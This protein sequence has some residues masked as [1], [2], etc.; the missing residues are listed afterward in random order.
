MPPDASRHRSPIR[1]SNFTLSQG[2]ADHFGHVKAGASRPALRA[3]TAL[4]RPNR[5]AQWLPCGRHGVHHRPVRPRPTIRGRR[6]GRRV[7]PNLQRLVRQA[8]RQPP[9]PHS[10]CNV[11]P[12]RRSSR[13]A[14]AHR[15]FYAQVISVQ[16]C[17]AR[18]AVP[19]PLRYSPTFRLTFASPENPRAR[20]AAGVTSM[21]RPRVKGPRSLIVTITERPLLLLVTRTLVPKGSVR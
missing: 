17:P 6:R 3:A 10:S 20:A 5:S 14:S 16:A 8:F 19:S 18:L 12:G 4:A 9:G 13:T 1:M 11:T 21:I 7:E 15:G 2:I